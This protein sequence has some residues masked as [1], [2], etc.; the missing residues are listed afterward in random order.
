MGRRRVT[1]CAAWVRRPASPQSSA[2]RRQTLL[3]LATAVFAAS[4]RSDPRRRHGRETCRPAR[5]T[6]RVA[7]GAAGPGFVAVAV[8]SHGHCSASR[9]GFCEDAGQQGGACGVWPLQGTLSTFGGPGLMLTLSYAWGGSTRF[10]SH[11][12]YTAVSWPWRR[13]W[14]GVV[15][16]SGDDSCRSCVE[17]R[18]GTRAAPGASPQTSGRQEPRPHAPS[19][20]S[21]SEFLWL[22]CTLDTES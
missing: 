19:S 18:R 6:P 12:G 20:L 15:V 11:L 3:P 4:P 5:V 8:L 9:P 1:A 21:L 7:R 10:R 17:G 16:G 2:L 13:V 22:L 14:Q